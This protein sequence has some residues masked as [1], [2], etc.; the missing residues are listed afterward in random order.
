MLV[1]FIFTVINQT[2]LICLEK[3]TVLCYPSSTKKA[4]NFK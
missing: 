4:Y 2:A 3:Q 1:K